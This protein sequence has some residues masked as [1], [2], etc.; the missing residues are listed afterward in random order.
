MSEKSKMSELEKHR[1]KID[2]I[3]GKILKLLRDRMK[4][5]E[6]IKQYKKK[7]NLRVTDKKREKIIF[8]KLNKETEKLKLDNRYVRKIFKVIMKRSKKVQKVS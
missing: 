2:E 1:K 8:Q 5:V 4:I 6:K 3:D 7:H